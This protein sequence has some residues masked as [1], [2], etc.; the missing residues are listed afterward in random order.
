MSSVFLSYDRDDGD[1]ARPIAKALEK[2]GHSVWW[3][4]H[5]GGG[6][7]Y[8]KEIEQ[9]LNGADVVVVLWSSSAVE[10]PW[11]RDEAGSG[12][13]KGRLVPL[14]IEGTLPPLGFRQFQSID[15]GSWRGRGRVPRLREILAAIERQSSDPGIPAPVQAFAGRPRRDGPSLNMWAVIGVAIGMFFVIVG[16]LIGRPWERSDSERLLVSTVPADNSPGSNAMAHALFSKL[17]TFAEIGSGKWQLV[18]PNAGARADLLVEAAKNVSDQERKAT[19]TLLDGKDRSVLWSRNFDLPGVSPEDLQQQ[20][21][22]TAGRVLGCAV[23]GLASGGKALRQQTLK[24]YLTGCSQLPEAG[25]DGASSV[26]TVLEQV[27]RDAPGFKAASAKLLLAESADG[28]GLQDPANPNRQILQRSIDRARQLDPKM[29]E[30]A[31]AKAQL[32]PRRAYGEALRL[33]DDAHANSPENADVL[34]YRTDAL[35]RVGRLSDAIADAA[36]AA[37]LD[38]TSPEVLSNYVL[39]LAYSGRIQAAR[40]QLQ[41]AEA[42]WAGT[43]KLRDLDYGF[44]LRFGDPKALLST[45]DFKRSTPAAQMYYRTRADPSP[46][47]VDRFV[48]MLRQLHARRGVHA[49]DVA[50][51]AQPYGEF[52]RENELYQMISKIPATE[53]ISL[54]SDVVF[55]PGLR[56]FRQDPR[57]MIVAKRIGLVDYWNKT[58]KWPDFCFVDPDQ[59]YDC[60]AEAAKLE[61]ART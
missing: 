11:V 31:I 9:A 25:N 52:H 12:R 14:S 16:L 13:D 54:F 5:I 53:D 20:V 36:Q 29:P 32:L 3:D 33:L 59:P 43:G 28:P 24:L 26:A 17:S 48:A 35:M 6:T 51:H 22:L 30:I 19:L 49:D 47:N 27:V 37:Q 34:M 55:R 40:E 21:S 4:K 45:E 1:K 50:G 61:G 18:Q 15:L 41:H 44:Q 38:P 60:K 56:K 10:S 8:A 7:Q 39:A 57:F 46:A 2:A 23:E 42:L 58:G